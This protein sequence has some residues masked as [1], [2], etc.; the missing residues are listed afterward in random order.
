MSITPNLDAQRQ[1]TFLYLFH[2]PKHPSVWL[3]DDMATNVH[4]VMKGKGFWEG[5]LNI[6]KRA[7]LIVSELIE[8]L[9]DLRN[10]PEVREPLWKCMDYVFNA[11]DTYGHSSKEY[12]VAY[13]TH[14]KD[15][16]ESEIAGTCI[17]LFDMLGWAYSTTGQK[18]T[19]DIDDRSSGSV[20]K[21]PSDIYELMTNVSTL[22]LNAVTN[23]K[24]E[25]DKALE[26]GIIEACTDAVLIIEKWA[27]N[28][29]LPIH[30]LVSYEMM[31]NLSRPYKHGK[32]F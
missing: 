27:E 23:V 32:A 20:V 13:R 16:W 17:R 10:K 11:F 14:L 22:L 28:T 2:D 4:E 15:R 1:T 31:Y 18:N 29:L 12:I 7:M 5:D 8:A 21:I 26:K 30:S 6:H 9:E 24:H 19:D 25:G 3:L